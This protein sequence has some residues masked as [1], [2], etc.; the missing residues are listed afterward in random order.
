M[1]V[2]ILIVDDNP[3]FVAAVRQI[4]AL[5]VSCRSDFVIKLLPAI[6]ALVARSHPQHRAT[7]RCLHPEAGP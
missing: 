1:P 5:A 7:L 4:G 6:E 2:R 3:A